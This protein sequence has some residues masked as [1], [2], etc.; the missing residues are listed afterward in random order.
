[1]VVLFF[2]C[3]G[4]FA[5][6]DFTE[7]DDL[8]FH[9]EIDQVQSKLESLLP[10]ATSNEDKAAVLWRLARNCVDR[11]DALPEDDKKGK[12]AI[13]EEGEAYAD[14]SIDAK[15]TPDGY[16][17]KCSNIGRWGQTKGALN[18]LSKAEPMRDIL[19]TVINDLNYQESSDVWYVL[20]SLYDQLPGGLI[21]FGN[22]NMAVSYMRLAVEK[23]PS[24]VW[25]GGT[26]QYL[27]EMLYK[28][29]WDAK[30]RNSELPKMLKSYDKETKNT[31]KKMGYYEGKLSPS[32]VPF[33]ATKSLGSMSDREEA[34]AVLNYALEV[35]K[36]RSFHTAGDEKNYAEIT[37]LLN[38]W[39]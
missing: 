6:M 4:L 12:Y 28:R 13:Y 10:K 15:E 2:V 17:W 26:Y 34:I 20:G 33:Y 27:A 7:I 38:E 30:K 32:Y 39:K 5:A 1:M 19:W 25:Y 23:I 21:S 16:I 11:G 9:S 22:S 36:K 29:N 8:Y 37:A 14:Q 31:C 3:S 24:W 35:Y 18:S